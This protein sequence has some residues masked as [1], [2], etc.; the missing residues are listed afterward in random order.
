M[1]FYGDHVLPRLV[2]VLMRAR[3]TH[4]VRARVASNLTGDVL[5]I[6]FG[7]G[8]NVPFYPAGLSR[9]YALDPAT[10]GR[11]LAAERVVASPVPVEYIGLDA[12]RIPLAD[13]SVDSVLTTWTLCTI[14]D[15]AQALAEVRRVLRPGGALHFVE[16]G[17]APDPKVARRQDLLEPIQQ[18][19]FGGCQLTRHIDQLISASGLELTGLKSYYRPG[20]PTTSYTYE[21]QARHQPTGRDST[22]RT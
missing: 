16:H 7:S 13:G 9:V 22:D 8:L 6:G 19:V 17:R 11:K 12:Q 3:D 4:D 5:E 10:V 18:R 2:D 1:S 15:P 20:P 14:P 21:G